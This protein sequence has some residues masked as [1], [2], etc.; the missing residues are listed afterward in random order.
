MLADV[1]AAAVGAEDPKL[2]ALPTVEEEV[3]GPLLPVGGPLVESFCFVS[4]FVEDGK[5]IAGAFDDGAAFASFLSVVVA[6]KL[7]M[8]GAFP[9]FLSAAPTLKELAVEGASFVAP[10]VNEA[11]AAVVVVAVAAVAV[12]GNENAGAEPLSFA[13]PANEKPVFGTLA[14]FFV[15]LAVKLG[16]GKVDVVEEVG[17]A[18]KLNVGAAEAVVAD[19]VESLAA[20]AKLKGFVIGAVELVELAA[21]PNAKPAA[22]GAVPLAEPK[23]KAGA[24]ADPLEEGPPNEGPDPELAPKFNPAVGA[25]AE[26]APKEKLGVAAAAALPLPPLTDVG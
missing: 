16:I 14:S 12:P 8:V 13:S 20:G 23:P 19:V 10:N 17:L 9:S 18:A 26:G 4:A 11:G 3:D 24:A 1:S 6:G 7:N 21:E 2:K 22:A 25:L 5:L 15:S